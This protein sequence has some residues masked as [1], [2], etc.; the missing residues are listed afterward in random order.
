MARTVWDALKLILAWLVL[1]CLTAVIALQLHGLVITL[2]WSVI[3]SDQLRPTGW[4]SATILT[5]SKFAVLVVGSM[6]LF[7]VVLLEGLLQRWG[8]ADLLIKRISQTAGILVVSALFLFL[9]G[10]MLG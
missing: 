4:T 9:V 1:A 7:T 5:L 10:L 2:G 6:W 3:Q 8:K